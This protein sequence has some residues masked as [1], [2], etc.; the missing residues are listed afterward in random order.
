MPGERSF[1]NEFGFTLGGAADLK[2]TAGETGVLLELDIFVIRVTAGGIEKEQAKGVAGP[3]IVAEVALQARLLD[4]GLFMNGG[5]R[6]GGGAGDFAETG[7]IS[8][9]AT[10]DGVDE[11]GTGRAK[12]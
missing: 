3:A 12:I 5:D 10:Q 1:A 8:L 11:G 7:V 6:T 4:A 2:N 9:R